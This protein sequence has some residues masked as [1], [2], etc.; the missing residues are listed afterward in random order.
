MEASLYIHNLCDDI[1]KHITLIKD[2]ED[3]KIHKKANVKKIKQ[4]SNVDNRESF[5]D[6]SMEILEY[7]GQYDKNCNKKLELMNTKI[8]YSK[9]KTVIKTNWKYI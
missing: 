7:L 1:N 5:V 3:K 8:I 6:V 4:N 9:S 2:L